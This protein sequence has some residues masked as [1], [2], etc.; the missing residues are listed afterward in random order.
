MGA[1]LPITLNGERS[2]H[3]GVLVTLTCTVIESCRKNSCGSSGS[4]RKG[5][6]GSKPPLARKP[7]PLRLTPEPLTK[8]IHETEPTHL[9]K[10]L[11]AR[12]RDTGVSHMHNG[13]PLNG[14][15]EAKLGTA[16]SPN[17]YGSQVRYGACQTRN[18]SHRRNAGSS[19]AT[20]A[21]RQADLPI[22]E[23]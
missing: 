1:V 22:S 14:P 4:L 5:L 19:P 15:A 10:P 6:S 17:P 20:Q 21:I 13:A 7:E 8:T 3:R 12:S 11:R 18:G 9:R 23:T 16:G 2:G